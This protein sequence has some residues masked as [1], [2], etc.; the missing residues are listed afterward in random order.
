M[1][2]HNIKFI[3]LAILYNYEPSK[4]LIAYQNLISNDRF[5]SKHEFEKNLDF[6]QRP[7]AFYVLINYVR[8]L[9]YRII[10]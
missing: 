10:K 4:L 9:L 1:I 5:C 6:H 7:V 8:I 3:E 2:I